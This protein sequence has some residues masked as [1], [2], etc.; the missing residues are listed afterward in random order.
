ML[1]AAHYVNHWRQHFYVTGIAVP[2]PVLNTAQKIDSFRHF[3]KGWH[4]GEGEPALEIA[5]RIAEHILWEFAKGGA[6]DT[7]AFPGTSGEV[8]V[9]AYIGSHYLEAIAESDGSVSLAYELDDVELFAKPRMPLKDAIAKVQEI[10]GAV[11]RSTFGSYILNIS[12]TAPHKTASRVWLS[13]TQPGAE[14]LLCNGPVSMRQTPQFATTLDDTT[15]PLPPESLQFFGYLTRPSS[16][17]D[18]A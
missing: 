16:Q 13:E 3:P 5:A 8:M 7:E 15:L 10:L 2:T 4:Y 18:I 17:Q 14:R 12:T 9:T 1:N 6:S 11:W